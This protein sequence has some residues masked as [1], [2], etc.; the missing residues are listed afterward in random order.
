[1]SLDSEFRN[2]VGR[3]SYPNAERGQKLEIGFCI[4][5]AMRTS[6][7]TSGQS[8]RIPKISAVG[9]SSSKFVQKLQ[10]S[11]FDSIIWPQEIST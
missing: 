4:L 6:T 9:G 1:M 5:Q 8:T 11:V 3:T 2:S 10:K 7:C